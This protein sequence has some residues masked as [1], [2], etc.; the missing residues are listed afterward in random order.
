[1]RTRP[2]AAFHL[3]LW[4]ALP[5]LWTVYLCLTGGKPASLSWA[6]Y[7]YAGLLSAFGPYATLL[8]G[9]GDLPNA[10]EFF[11]ITSALVLTIPLLAVVSLPYM[12]KLKWVHIVCCVLYVPVI[13]LWVACGIVQIGSCII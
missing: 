1:M 4:I 8:A 13:L 7:I 9:L 11:K 3:L 5:T 6:Q 2:L 10:G 12:V